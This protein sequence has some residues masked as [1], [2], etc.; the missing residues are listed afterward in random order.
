MLN[1]AVTPLDI[2]RA[3]RMYGRDVPSIKGKTTN[4]LNTLCKE[5]LVPMSL[6]K[7]QNVSMDIFYWKGNSFLLAVL[8]PL[9]FNMVQYIPSH[10][11]SVLKDAVMRIVTKIRARGFIIN[12]VITDPESSLKTL[13]GLVDV[14]WDTVGSRTHVEHAER[15]VRVIKE[16]LRATEY[17]VKFRIAKRFAKWTVY[18]CVSALNVTRQNIDGLS[19]RE[20]FTGIKCDYKRDFRIAFGD[21]AQVHVAPIPSRTGRTHSR[22]NCFMWCWEQ[23]GIGILVRSED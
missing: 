8:K 12:T 19:A 22:G 3:T 13:D 4:H 18:G 10:H 5:L 9:D 15:E 11:A 7:E 23:K 2:I 21:Y 16:R 14:P 1:T 20:S 17:G 6:Q